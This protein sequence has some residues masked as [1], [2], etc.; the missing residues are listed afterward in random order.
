MIMKSD[1]S[2]SKWIASIKSI[3]FAL[4]LLFLFSTCSK[5]EQGDFQSIFDGSTFTGWEGDKDF[6][7]IENGAIVAGSLDREI[8]VNQFLCTEKSYGDF[9]LRVKVKF[10]SRENNAGIQFRTSRIPN[11]HEVIGYQAD[12]GFVSSGPVW[13]SLYDESRRNKFLVKASDEE[14]LK[15]LKPNGWNDYRIRAEGAHIQ[16]WLNGKSIMEYVEED[17]SIARSGVICVQIHSGVPA[18]AW[19]KDI[20]ILQ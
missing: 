4:G 19:Y 15:I 1:S 11:D 2:I 13:G 7:R 18:E 9:E 12:V 16:F 3:L 5:Q 8:P 10:T 17:D 20:M 6:F 14:V